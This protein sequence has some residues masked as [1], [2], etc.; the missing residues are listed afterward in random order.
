MIGG[1]MTFKGEFVLSNFTC[2]F[3]CQREENWYTPLSNSQQFGCNWDFKK[4]IWIS[5]S[6]LVT[7]VEQ[8]N[9]LTPLTEHWIY[10]N[11]K[12]V[13]KEIYTKFKKPSY[14]FNET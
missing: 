4:L 1:N 7:K 8:H 9:F 14:N 11:F 10:N 5:N 2:G 13:Q 12:V 3:Y 6:Y